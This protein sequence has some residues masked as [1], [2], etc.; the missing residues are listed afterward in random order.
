M[1]II[2]STLNNSMSVRLIK[3]FE[4]SSL[5]MDTWFL[6]KKTRYMKNLKLNDK[7]IN[8]ALLCSMYVKQFY[9]ILNEINVC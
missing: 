8:E 1:L 7:S 4:S 2:Q 3:S 5:R 9:T 6:E